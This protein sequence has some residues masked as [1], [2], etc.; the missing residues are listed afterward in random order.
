MKKPIVE[1]EKLVVFYENALALKFRVYLL[2]R[3]R[4]LRIEKELQSW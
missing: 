1:V 4:I 3:L 2:R